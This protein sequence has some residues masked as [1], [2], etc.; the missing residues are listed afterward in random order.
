MI[1][2]TDPFRNQITL[3]HAA[4]KAPGEHDQRHYLDEMKHAVMVER[5]HNRH[6]DGAGRLNR[7]GHDVQ[8][9]AGRDGPSTCETPLVK[10][11]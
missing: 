5:N 7:R 10:A 6:G 3:S 4:G 9:D 1:I 2:V 11:C 8:R